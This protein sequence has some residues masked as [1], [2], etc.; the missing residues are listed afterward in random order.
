M[1]YLERLIT[2]IES[3]FF[4]A[5]IVKSTKMTNKAIRQA[6]LHCD[7]HQL[8]DSVL[9]DMIKCIPKPDQIKILQE[10]PA[11]EQAELV[12]AEKLALEVMLVVHG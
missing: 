11:S 9:Q 10:L 3:W 7:T 12:D 5:I 6:I 4:I 2:N 1:R 8:S